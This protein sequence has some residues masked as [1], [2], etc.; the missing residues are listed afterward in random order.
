MIVTIPMYGRNLFRWKRERMRRMKEKEREEWRGNSTLL[1]CQW[2][3]N[4]LTTAVLDCRVL[5]H[6]Q[7]CCP[8]L[9]GAPLNHP[10]LEEEKRK[11]LWVE[12]KKKGKIGS[13]QICATF[14]GHGVS[15]AQLESLSLGHERRQSLQHE[16]VHHPLLEKVNLRDKTL[17]PYSHCCMSAKGNWIPSKTRSE[18]FSGCCYLN[19]TTI[20]LSLPVMSISVFQIIKADAI[21]MPK[22]SAWVSTCWTKP[23]FFNQLQKFS[24]I[25]KKN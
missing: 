6:R 19:T 1:L 7:S 21:I 16:K 14:R 2:C 23:E 12:K 18:S 25:E 17:F 4:D 13:A 24:S 22:F 20:G 8:L 9:S 15:C 3:E 5:G 10:V 11:D